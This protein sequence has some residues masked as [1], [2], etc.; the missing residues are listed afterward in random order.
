M[1]QWRHFARPV[2]GERGEDGRWGSLGVTEISTEHTAAQKFAR[3]NLRGAVL[4]Q[5]L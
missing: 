3:Q 1:L 5:W 4:N 2:E